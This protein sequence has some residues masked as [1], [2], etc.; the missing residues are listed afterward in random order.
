MLIGAHVSA[1][2]GV[3]KAV[4]RAHDLGAECFQ[5][6]ASSPRAWAVK[7]P[8]EQEA[9]A[10]RSAIEE[11]G[12]GPVVLHGKYLIA[13]GASDDALVERSIAALVSDMKAADALGALGVIFHPASHRGRGFDAVS[14]QFT[15]G[16]RSV[17]DASPK[18]PL[19]MLENS[20]GAGDHIGSKFEEL[21]RLIDAVDDPR[22]AICLDT[23][24][25][26][27]AGWD[28]G[29]AETLAEM[30]RCIDETVGLDKLRA[31]HAND[32]K[33][34]LGSA[35][36]RHENIG[37]GDIGEE[38]FHTFM[39][40]PAFRDVPFYLEVPG[41]DGKG[42]DKPNVDTLKRIRSAVLGAA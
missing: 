17:L 20:A 10:F 40:H 12:M 19:L 13:L 35:V 32:S 36:D 5:I 2:G 41:M 30:V 24:H 42:P 11:K 15:A 6:F 7:P 26:W 39:A 9:T 18:A 37:Y 23:Q 38:R 16:L 14:D 25:A 34:P 28:I 21:S 31:I 27:A 22:L 3:S 4:Q 8:P 33:K 1:A 29:G